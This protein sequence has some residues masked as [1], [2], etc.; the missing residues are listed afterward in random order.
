MHA[1]DNAL[2]LK[3]AQLEGPRWNTDL[4]PQFISDFPVLAL[5]LQTL[6]HPLRGGRMV[7]S[8]PRL[9]HLRPF[10]GE[11]FRV[12]LC[13][14]KD[15]LWDVAGHSCVV[16]LGQ[17]GILPF[18]V[19]LVLLHDLLDLVGS[20]FGPHEELMIFLALPH[21]PVYDVPE[22]LL[23]FR[24]PD[25][26]DDALAVLQALQ[27]R[28]HGEGLTALLN[29]HG[30]LALELLKLALQLQEGPAIDA[31][32]HDAV[33]PMLLAVA[34]KVLQELLEFVVGPVWTLLLIRLSEW[35]QG[36]G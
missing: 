19:L 30:N 23:V 6:E 35:P 18:Q 15:L 8:Q 14:G 21:R 11:P 16:Q 29:I 22:G 24:F 13:H 28:V 36:A 33:L 17:V 34:R 7:A 20:S 2:V 5:I 31:E 10:K 3:L 27:Q 9:F 26:V 1:D 32:P 25:S 4:V 12:L